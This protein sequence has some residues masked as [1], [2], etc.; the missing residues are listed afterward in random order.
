MKTHFFGKQGYTSTNIE[1]DKTIIVVEFINDTD[2]YHRTQ[3]RKTS[4]KKHDPIC[5]PL[6]F[7]L[8]SIK[9]DQYIRFEINRKIW[10]WMDD[11]YRGTQK[12]FAKT[13]STQS[14]YAH[15]KIA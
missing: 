5:L 12:I 2:G 9:L 6:M 1:G 3:K 15:M 4:T 8:V 13:R 11:S 10:I 7:G 14:I